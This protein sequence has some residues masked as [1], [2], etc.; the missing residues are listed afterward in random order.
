MSLIQD[1]ATYKENVLYAQP[2]VFIGSN[3]VLL[4]FFF[5][6]AGFPK[7]VS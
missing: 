4:K 7:G 5:A 3:F 6:N 1:C 2:R